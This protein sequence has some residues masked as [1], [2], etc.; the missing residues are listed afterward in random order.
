VTLFSYILRQLAV[1]VA[2][3][4][5]GLFFIAIPGVV[6]SAVH[7]LGGVSMGALLRFLPLVL[8]DLVP[9]LLPI[10]FLLAVVATYG[11]LAG[12]KEWT[13]I[14][15]AGIHPMR[16]LIPALVLATL[17]GGLTQW[18]SSEISPSLSL[19]KRQ[20]MRNTIVEG[21]REL[22]PGQTEIDF[23][24]K[25]YLS[26]QF[27]DADNTFRNVLIHLPS[28]EDGGDSDRERTVLADR[29]TFSVAN[30][31][32]RID[33]E[34]ARS[35]DAYQDFHVGRFVAELDLNQ[36][37][38]VN[39]RHRRAWRFLTSSE[40]KQAVQRGVVPA[41]EV[42]QAIYELH[43]RDALTASYFLFILLG[44]PTGLIMRRG[45]QLGALAVAV[46]YAL[47]YYLLNMRLGKTLGEWGTIP[48]A[49]AAWA[50]TLIG[51]AGGLLLW[52]KVLRR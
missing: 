43:R 23:G 14:A 27:R 50:T 7:Q 10:G 32:I 15:M 44:A 19:R 51:F 4:A 8:I 2:F 16:A 20:F 52:W 41:D 37:F 47:L 48:P 45:T 38:K 34:N 39:P 17:L 25:F 24:G 36:L 1:S 21:L 42:R 3:A 13:A 49:F 9:Y 33:L 22:E 29:A 12:D 18:L 40:L 5:G 11:R 31:R 46:G 6:V 30:D 26:S 28:R 35:A